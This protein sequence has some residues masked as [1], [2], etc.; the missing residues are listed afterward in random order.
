M[1]FLSIIQQSFL[2][3]DIPVK[4]LDKILTSLHYEVVHYNKG[5]I[6]FCPHKKSDIL[7]ILL[8]GQL[9]VKRYSA[10]GNSILLDTLKPGNLVAAPSVFSSNPYY[11]STIIATTAC[12]IM[13]IKKDDMLVLLR[14]NPSIQFAFLE[15]IS[16]Q[17]LYMSSRV[18]LISQPSLKVRVISYLLNQYEKTQNHC[19]DLPYSKKKWADYLYVQPQSLSRILRQLE[20]D[21]LLRFK[22]RKIF[23]LNIPSLYELINV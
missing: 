9:E 14:D 5:S 3:K 20:E 2:F 10:F 1:V 7:G 11:P 19:I 23:L 16:N 12:D 6:V 22:G 15:L 13:L 18:D 17:V 21:G 4:E 8:C